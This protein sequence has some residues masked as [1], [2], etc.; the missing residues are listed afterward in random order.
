[1]LAHRLRRLP[2]VA[3]LEA[4]LLACY[5]LLIA[6]SVTLSEKLCFEGP[7]RDAPK[8]E[9][10]REGAKRGEA[11]RKA[12][13]EPAGRVSGRGRVTLHERGGVI[14]TALPPRCQY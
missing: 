6:L 1:M 13:R 12:L 9:V 10:R 5:R 3:S 14:D 4:E 8:S 2:S 11:G 7:E